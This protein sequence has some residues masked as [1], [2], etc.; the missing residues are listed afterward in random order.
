VIECDKPVGTCP[1]IAIANLTT[2][3]KES[4]FEVIRDFVKTYESKERVL[5]ISEED[6]PKTN[7]VIFSKNSYLLISY[8]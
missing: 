4:I 7:F 8:C 6:M 2:K 1:V 5:L 3:G